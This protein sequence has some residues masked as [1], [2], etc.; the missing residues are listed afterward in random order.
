MEIHLP[1][2]SSR[3]DCAAADYDRETGIYALLGTLIS[4]H[5]ITLFLVVLLGI[6]LYARKQ[7]RDVELRY[8]WLTL[9][10]C[11]LLVVQDSLESIAA[12][13][14]GLRFWRTLFSAAGYMLRPT[15]AVGLLLVVT[16]PEQRKWRIWIPWYINFAANMTAFFSPLAFS[17]DE[18]YDFVRGPLGYVVFI[19]SFWYMIRILMM[20]WKRFYEGVTAERW[21][22][23]ICVIGCMLASVADAL[24]GGVHLTEAIMISSVFLFIYLRSHDNYLDP[25]T[26][27]RNRF[28]F[29]DDSEHLDR[30]ITAVA[31][32]DMNGLKKLNDTKGHM[33]GDKA[34]TE[35]GRCL[36]ENSDRN[37]IAYRIGGDEFALLFIRQSEEEA[38]ETIR[39]IKE[40]VA[41]SG[42]SVSAGYVMKAADQNLEDT[43]Q[44]SDREMYKDKAA[45]YQQSGRDRRSRARD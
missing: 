45:Y 38:A 24:F 8:Y 15:A 32:L 11:F 25:L 40:S 41:A 5:Y 16:P 3:A 31:S 7:S 1:A 30:D 35:I 13:D 42:Y 12:T 27:L 23:V 20:V 28:A 36:S 26:S 2:A 33:E 9:V 22:L 21:I 43:M 14:P 34:L 6:K 29:Y 4:T 19:V 37:T 10:C 18:N 44:A 17:F 39:R